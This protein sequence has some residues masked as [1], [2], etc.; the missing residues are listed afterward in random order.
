LFQKIRQ[1]F[2]HLLIYGLGDTATQI[3]SFLL[4]PLY[5]RYLS[6][7]DYGVLSLLLATE[8]VTKILFRWGID[9]SFMRLY[10]DC[11][12]APSRQKLASTQFLFLLAV[13]GTLLAIGLLA[14]RPLGEHLF[15][16]TQY[17][18]V[19]RMVFINTF[20]VG[21]YYLPF[22]VMR[23]EGRARTFV[24]L[25][26]TRSAATLV[27]RLVFVIAAGL[28]VLGVVVAD[29]AVTAAFTL[30]LAWWFVPLIR[31]VFSK[32]LLRQSLRFGVPRIPHGV[33][34]QVIAVFDRYLL[35][36]FVT[37]H[38]LGL[39]ATGA[40]IGLGLKLFLSAFESAWAPFYFGVM[41]EPDA[42]ETFSRVTTY[43][44]AVLVLLTASLSAIANDLV[45]LMTTSAFQPAARVIPWIALGVTLQGVYLLTSI[46][47]NITK[48]TEY[49]PLATGLAAS[50]SVASNIILV[51]RM[52]IVGA[53]IS[54]TLAYAVL[55]ATS[56]WFS[57][58]FYPIAYERGRLARIV[59]AGIVAFGTSRLVP[60]EWGALPSL[61]AR[62]SLV[63]LVFGTV[64]AAT[65]FFVSGEI[66]KL[67]SLAARLR[68]RKIIERPADTTE[69]A[70]EFVATVTTDDAEAVDEGDA[71]GVPKP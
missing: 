18:N 42:K 49:Y 7:A 41:R 11:P 21:F 39:Y 59:I 3:I 36:R 51:P 46:G 9:A 13:N 1:L 64:L 23:I 71:A 5:V 63:V 68:R 57:R 22:H 30:L 2:G 43:G 53:A 12:D 4:L 8:V 54:N 20:V 33:A 47:L 34:H 65:G 66:E 38:E 55:A 70:G 45:L 67:S 50:A 69:M 14:A 60:D 56:W 61:V 40:S 62:G 37:L 52:G 19:L 27:M 58:R 15:G 28:G 6:P 25:A 44:V 24:T 32:D 17:T 48:H 31:P 35:A 29:L 26:F 16:T 10:Y